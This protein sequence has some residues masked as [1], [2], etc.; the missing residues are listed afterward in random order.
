MTALPVLVAQWFSGLWSVPIY[1]AL[2]ILLIIECSFVLLQILWLMRQTWKIQDATRSREHF[3]E[4]L[5]ASF[6]DA[7]EDSDDRADWVRQ[8]RSFPEPV[9]RE[10]IEGYILRTDGAYRE[11]II[12]MYRDL[13]LLWLDLEDLRSPAWQIRMIALRRMFLAA[14]RSEHDALLERK[15]DIYPIRIMAAR[16]LARVGTAEDLVELLQDLYL[17]R[18]LMEQ[19]LVSMLNTMPIGTYEGLMKSWTKLHSPRLRRTVLISSARVVPSVCMDWLPR[20]AQAPEVDVRVGACIAAGLL[21]V[22]ASRNLLLALLDDTSWEVRA[23]A[24]A[25]LGEQRDLSSIPVLG[26]LLHDPSFWVRQHAALSIRIHGQE[27][28]EF[29]R[30][31][32]GTDPDKYAKDAAGQELERHDLEV[33]TMGGLLE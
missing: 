27:G 20:A 23:Q 32:H 4:T 15:D 2:L 14:T 25:A 8:A 12:D 22:E 17:S 21:P 24:A 13:G 29:L 16:V 18:R 7:L 26:K 9:I 28:L 10:F 1:R 33:Q 30:N 5:G 6:F 31:V 3:M 19:P 11:L